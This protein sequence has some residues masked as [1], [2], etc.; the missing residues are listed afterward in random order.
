MELAG[1]MQIE[2]SPQE[3]SEVVRKAGTNCLISRK[4]VSYSFAQPYDFIPSL[5]ASSHV[6]TSNPSP[7]LGDENG[8]SI[9]WCPRQDLKD[10]NKP[11]KPKY[12]Q[13]IKA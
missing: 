6:S 11:S 5:L 13:A 7:S 2:K 3:I 1:K 9:I 10:C 8:G 12:L 4:T